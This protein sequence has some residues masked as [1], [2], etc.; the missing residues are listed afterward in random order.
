MWHSIESQCDQVFKTFKK[1]SIII[2]LF[3][4]NSFIAAILQVECAWVC[5]MELV[6]VNGCRYLFWFLYHT[7][8]FIFQMKHDRH[9]V[10]MW[11]MQSSV[12][13]QEAKDTPT[14]SNYTICTSMWVRLVYCMRDACM[15]NAKSMSN[16]SDDC[17]FA[18]C[19][20]RSLSMLLRHFVCDKKMCY[21]TEKWL[22]GIIKSTRCETHSFYLYPVKFRLFGDERYMFYERHWNKKNIYSLIMKFIHCNWRSD[23]FNQFSV[24]LVLL[25][26]ECKTVLL[27]VNLMDL[28]IESQMDVW[29]WNW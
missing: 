20:I 22:D 18:L 26:P 11:L 24:W 27:C 4:N 5:W 19:L 21:S 2:M 3:N 16:L 8:M 6:Y 28:C 23:L 7:Q 12:A 9:F 1:V 13:F 29:L 10:Y 25:Q 17:G 15:Q 14:D